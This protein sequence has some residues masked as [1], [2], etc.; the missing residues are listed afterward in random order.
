MT[1]SNSA[2]ALID[3]FDS[4]KNLGLTQIGYKRD[5]GAYRRR[6]LI[7]EAGLN[8]D[9]VE[10]FTAYLD[11]LIEQAQEDENLKVSERELAKKGLEIFNNPVAQAKFLRH[12]YYAPIRSDIGH[13][14]NASWSG[15]KNWVEIGRKKF[16]AESDEYNLMQAVYIALTRD[17]R[18]KLF[19]VLDSLGKE[20]F[21]Q[22][23][24]A[25][26]DSEDLILRSIKKAEKGFEGNESILRYLNR[27]R[28]TVLS[29]NYLARKAF[30]SVAQEPIRLKDTEFKLSNL[31]KSLY[32]KG[33]EILMNLDLDNDIKLKS[34]P[35]LL[36]NVMNN[37]NSNC[38]KA[39]KK[40]HNYIESQKIQDED[41][42]DWDDDELE[43]IDQEEIKDITK[44]G[45]VDVK[46]SSEEVND[47]VIIKVQDR[48][49]GIPPENIKKIWDLGFTTG[50]EGF[51][52]AN[53]KNDLALIG[54]LIE[55]ENPGRTKEELDQANPENFTS[56]KITLPSNLVVE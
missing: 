45:L 47:Q 56:F 41:H 55:L 15:A 9:Q 39:V 43:E 36:K 30:A 6:L 46:I 52:L 21:H 37:L 5:L 7:K 16:D 1:A 40:V 17:Y 24:G 10:Q 3:R 34:D 26:V 42:D 22:K 54:A 50:G 44:D 38:Q 31:I 51:G 28:Y 2:L 20:D 12:A 29:M 11:T 8:A 35:G 53:V 23:L 19:D 25:L 32:H 33:D 18:P 48:G 27:A 4:T 49:I 13:D 14:V